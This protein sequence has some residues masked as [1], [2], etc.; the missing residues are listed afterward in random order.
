MTHDAIIRSPYPDPEIPALSLVEY[1]LGDA[2]E[3]GGTP[4][5]IFAATGR[6]IS[7]AELESAAHKVAAALLARGLRKSDTFAICSPNSLE[8]AVAYYGI[9]AAG[10]A[11]TTI[12]PAATDREALGLLR[13]SG[14]RWLLTTPGLA[15]KLSAA[16]TEAN[17]REVFIAGDAG[18]DRG[19]TLF[20]SLLEGDAGA[21]LPPIS[22][23]DVAVVLYSSGTTGLPKGVVH[24]HRSMVAGLC[25]E[26]AAIPAGEDDVELAVLPLYHI[27][28]MHIVMNAALASGAA[29]V[30]MPRFDLESFLAAIQRY[31]VTRAVVAPPIVLAL[32][33]HPLVD[34][35]DLSSLKVLRCGAAPLDGDLARACARR[36]GCRVNQGYGMTETAACTFAPDVGPEKPE[37]VGP[38]APGV[39][40]RVV[41][42]ITGSDLAP[43]ETG[44]LLVRAASVM[45]GYLNNGAATRA[46]IDEADWLHTGDVVRIDTDGWIHI[47]DRIKELIKYKGH[48]VAPAELEAVL[49]AHSAVG[50]VAVIGSPDDEAGEVPKAFVVLQGEAGADELMEFAAARVAPHKKIR[51]LEFVDA[52]PKSPSGKILRRLLVERERAARRQTPAEAVA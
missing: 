7:Y 48:Q 30:V 39:E 9:L 14:A 12:N 31:H 35:Y 42:W 29:L 27:A 20:A 3:R 22:P 16:I 43:G 28:G 40:C 24:T 18:D 10:G 36:L 50:D 19:G 8:F 37:S 33:K 38:P 13:D 26:R 41:D 6:R 23:D 21:V 5:L 32:A 1:V 52:I 46:T 51:R 47:T 15:E 44:E 25:S 11:V 2:G 17:L 45:R 49:L 34:C 4:A